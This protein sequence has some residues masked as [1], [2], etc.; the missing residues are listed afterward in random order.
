MPDDRL[1][2]CIDPVFLF[3]QARFCQKMLS[4]SEEGSSTS[5]CPL[6]MYEAWP[7]TL[8]VSAMKNMLSSVVES[9][10]ACGL[11]RMSS[12]PL[13]DKHLFTC[14]NVRLCGVKQLLSGQENT[15]EM[16]IEGAVNLTE[17]TLSS[18]FIGARC[19]RQRV[20]VS[21]K[22]CHRQDV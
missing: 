3:L 10:N 16:Q 4:L 22:N 13:I 9:S 2:N 1:S 11:L 18:R 21:G 6:V 17:C 20:E 7:A 19:I 12:A 14:R 5:H 8:T 15:Q